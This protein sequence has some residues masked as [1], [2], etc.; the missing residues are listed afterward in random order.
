[1]SNQ[2]QNP[3]A[4]PTASYEPPEDRRPSRPTDVATRGQRLAG[5]LLIV[6]AALVF[7]DAVISTGTPEAGAAPPGMGFVPAMIDVGIG[8]SLLSGSRKTLRWAVIRVVIGLVVWS[9]MQ[10]VRGEWILMVLQ[11]LVGASF[12][13][14]LIGDAGRA[15]IAVGASAFGLFTLVS[16]LGIVVTVSG[17]NPLA[18]VIGSL[19]PDPDLEPAP[20]RQVT[21][22]ATGYSL[23][24]PNEKWHLRKAEAAKKDNPIVDRWLVRPE[25]DAHVLVIVEDV[26]NGNLPIE[27]YA[28]AILEGARKV[29]KNLTVLE[30][31]P[32]PGHPDDGLLIHTKSTMEKLD[33]EYYY[34]L[35]SDHEHAYQIIVFAQHRNFPALMAEVKQIIASFKL[36]PRGA[37][38]P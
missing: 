35:I 15:R 23:T 21:G 3:Y 34:A 30:R 36:P 14:L 12:L 17:G 8:V 22:V 18:S 28:D 11:A 33:L 5:A 38:T 1:M 20:A 19:R 13:L 31:G 25:S 4:P 32:L 16:L 7:I 10:L 26:P 9:G 24:L 2:D 29:A 27:G 37:P 6:N